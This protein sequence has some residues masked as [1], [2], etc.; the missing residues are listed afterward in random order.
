VALLA[1]L[2]LA[3]RLLLARLVLAARLLLVRRLAATAPLPLRAAAWLLLARRLRTG[4][5][6][7]YAD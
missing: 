1:R 6:P 3:A 5:E 7:R 2:V 4:T